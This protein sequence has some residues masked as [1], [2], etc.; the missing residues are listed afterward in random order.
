MVGHD[1]GHAAMT[2]IADIRSITT[3]GRGEPQRTLA[4]EL[5]NRYSW[6]PGYPSVA[7]DIEHHTRPREVLALVRG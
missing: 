6:A 7:E 5:A 1:A 3:W 4:A 2:L